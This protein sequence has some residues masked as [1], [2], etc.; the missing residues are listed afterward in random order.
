LKLSAVEH[1]TLKT[2]SFAPQNTRSS[3][4]PPAAAQQRWKETVLPTVRPTVLSV[5]DRR[6][7]EIPLFFGSIL[8]CSQSGDDPQEDLAR[9]YY[10]RNMKV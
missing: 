8:L 5:N 3:L 7:A 2:F 1:Q 6:K 10:K 9:F 4:D